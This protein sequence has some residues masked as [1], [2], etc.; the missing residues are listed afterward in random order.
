MEE[1]NQIVALEGLAEVARAREHPGKRPSLA[2]IR[3]SPGAYLAAASVL[4][5]SSGLLLRSQEDL[6]ALICLTA[7]WLLIPLLALS[8]RIAF[9]GVRLVRQGPLP[10]LLRV[11]SGRERQLRLPDFERV[12][13]HAVRTLRRGGR[14]R[15]RYRTQISG[16]GGVFVFAS[17]GKNYRRMVEVLFPLIDEEKMDV[18]T[19]ELRHYLIDPQTLN[20]E[21]A[22]LNLASDDVLDGATAN[23]KLKSERGD[24]LQSE[25]TAA[26]IARATQ[27]KLLG[28]K[29]RIGGRLREAGEAFRRALLVLPKDGWLIY[30]FAR[31]LRS[32]A[33]AQDDVRL[34]SRSRAALRLA[35][36]RAGP[37]GRLFS[38]IGESYLECGEIER[39]QRAF[40]KAIEFGKE[41]FRAHLGLAE[42][43]LRTG[44]LA[45][46]IH[47]YRDAAESSSEKALLSYS[48]R[49]ADYYAL[50]NDDDEYLSSELRR[51]N[52]LQQFV[53]IR[54]LAARST[55]ASILVALLAPYV[56]PGV[57]GLAW[58]L[59]TSSLVGWVLS[60]F[61]GRVFAVRRTA[62]SE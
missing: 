1:T 16:R 8:D 17:G 11:F 14:V 13:T 12:D 37:D 32:L 50:L 59:A 51:M 19:R 42:V 58:A 4:T 55:N 15:Y 41:K 46:V 36:L 62:P 56:E 43:A 26:D 48:R 29:L 21:V 31:L 10:F 53:R 45:H 27:L 18:R 25:L 33:S 22:A 5:F 23:F 49:E 40:Q 47:Q 7:A 60:L 3:V 34:L 52:W 2:S 24:Q 6:W 54:R 20:R 44:K 28:N 61:L 9:D 57:A 35:E 39:A 38:S 30:D